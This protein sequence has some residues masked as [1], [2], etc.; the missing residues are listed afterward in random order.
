V[1]S[2]GLCLKSRCLAR[3]LDGKLQR[4][5]AHGAGGRTAALGA[6]DPRETDFAAVMQHAKYTAI[7]RSQQEHRVEIPARAG[8]PRSQRQA[9]AVSVPVASVSVNPLQ[10]ANLQVL[11]NCSAHFEPRPAGALQPAHMGARQPQGIHVGEA[12]HRCL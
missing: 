11:R 5:P 9:L 12:A 8:R 4:S 10:I 2:G 1:V 3:G 6:G 7:A